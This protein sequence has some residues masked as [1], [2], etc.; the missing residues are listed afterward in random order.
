MPRRLELF[1]ANLHEENMRRRLFYI[2][3][4]EVG[5]RNTDRED[6]A[7]WLNDLA[8]W[9]TDYVLD[10]NPDFD[11][12]KLPLDINDEDLADSYATLAAEKRAQEIP[13]DK[14]VGDAKKE[15][16]PTAEPEADKE[17]WASSELT[18]K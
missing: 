13:E 15:K 5:R 6:F 1:W 10:V 12:A 8:N 16:E 11:L 9:Y 4:W 14:P 18:K 3:K 7:S 2:Y 17:K